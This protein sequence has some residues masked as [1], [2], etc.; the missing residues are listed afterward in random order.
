MFLY[1][2]YKKTRKD[3]NN[4]PIPFSR[5]PFSRKLKKWLDAA[6]PFVEDTYTERWHDYESLAE[7]LLSFSTMAKFQQATN[8]RSLELN[9]A[10]VEDRDPKDLCVLVKMLY[11]HFP[12]LE[13]LVVYNLG[14]MADTALIFGLRDYF[15][16]GRTGPPTWWKHTRTE[17]ILGFADEET[18][19]YILSGGWQQM[20]VG[21]ECYLDPRNGEKR[22]FRFRLTNEEPF[23][24]RVD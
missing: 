13:Q 7:H 11:E 17:D 2:K 5:I 21:F 12:L 3:S 18:K 10:V 19:S 6:R 15:I 23:K 4:R 9:T 20:P 8:L 22:Y 14:I 16:L 24:R 1:H